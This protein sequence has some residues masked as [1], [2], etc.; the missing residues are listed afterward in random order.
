MSHAHITNKYFN[1]IYM[2]IYT[3]I[4][5]S[6]A[7]KNDSLVKSSYSSC[8]RS[9]FVSQLPGPT[10]CSATENLPPTFGLEVEEG[11]ALIWTIPT[12]SNFFSK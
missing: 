10:Q 5:I 11:I 1:V 9:E 3:Y 4:L 8:R 6:G 7:W 12:T 2:Y